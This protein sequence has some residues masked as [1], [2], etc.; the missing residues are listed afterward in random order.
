MKLRRLTDEMV[1]NDDDREIDF[2]SAGL[3]VVGLQVVMATVM[4]AATSILC[5]ALLPAPAVSAVRTLAVTSTVGVILVHKPIRL[6]RVRGVTTVFNALRPSVLIYIQVQVLEQLVHTCVAPDATGDQGSWRKVIF[7]MMILLM[8][9]AGLLRARS[10]RSEF[11]IAFLISCVS[12]LVIALLPPPA[13]AFTG[14]LCSPTSLV[15]AGERLLRALLFSSLFVTHVY[16]AAPSHNAMNE[17]LL[18]VMRCTA[19][20][21]WVLGAT[22]IALPIAVL[23]LGM[24]MHTRMQENAGV[25]VHNS[26]GELGEMHNQ[27]YGA[28]DTRSDGNMS[29]TES[30]LNTSLHESSVSSVMN[31]TNGNNHQCT[32]SHMFMTSP[33]QH[34]EQAAGGAF[35]SY[36][37]FDARQIDCN[38]NDCDSVASGAID[39]RVSLGSLGSLGSSGSQS[40]NGLTTLTIRGTSM[41]ERGSSTV[42]NKSLHFNLAGVGGG[43]GGGGGR[44]ACIGAGAVDASAGVGGNN[45]Q[46]TCMSGCVATMRVQSGAGKVGKTVSPDR[47]AQIASQFAG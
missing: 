46:S 34:Y 38:S 1:L 7:H 3:Y 11:D 25:S 32:S 12:F 47:M 20:S 40:S 37:D 10:P 15:G 41:A 23:Q 4:C 22:T 33:A 29:D 45:G 28:V 16:A 13:K 9:M 14:P 43:G 31:D 17:L 27:P 8:I 36:T 30:G 6:G 21:V 5:C 35:A 2:Q 18:C 44:C 42:S 24:C 39:E 26:G 19:A